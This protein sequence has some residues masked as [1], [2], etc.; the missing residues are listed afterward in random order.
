MK[1]KI[2]RL[3]KGI[4]EYEMPELIVSETELNIDVEEGIRKSGSIRIT[5]DAGKRMKGVLYV[6][7]KILM[8]GKTD[9]IGAECELEYEVDATSLQAGEEHVGTIDIISD[10]GECQIPFRIHVSEPVFRTSVGNIRDLFQFANLARIN[11][12]EALDLFVSEEFSKVV[13]QKEPKYRLAYEQLSA[14]VDKP[15]AME[16]FLVLVHKKKHC[17]FEVV[18]ETSEYDVND[19]NFMES[20]VIKKNQWGYINISLQTNAPYILLT[21]NEITMDDFINGQAEIGFVIEAEKLNRGTHYAEIV[22]SA[23]RKEVRLPVTIHKSRKEDDAGTYGKGLHRLEY[24]LTELYLQFRNN[25]VSS[26]NYLSESARLIESILMLLDKQEMGNTDPVV[27]N[28]IEEKKCLYEL[29]RA[30]LSIVDGKNRGMDDSYEMILSRK[31]YFERNNKLFYCAV[32]Y[33]E[34]MKSRDRR[35]VEESADIIR[36]YYEQ[37]KKDDIILWFLLYMDKRLENSKLLRYEMIKKHCG[38]GSVSRIL[39]FEAAM[40][41]NAEPM[42]VSEISSFECQIMQYLLK[43]KLAGKETALQFAYLSEKS[44]EKDGVQIRILK[45]LYEQ[46]KHRDILFALCKKMIRNNYCGKD[47]HPY[48]KQGIQE[49]LRLDRLNEYY[50]MTLDKTANQLIEQQALLYFSMTNFATEEDAAFVYSYVVRNKDIN[51]A[52]YRAYLKKMEQFAVNQMKAGVISGFHAVLYADVLRPSIIDREMAQQLPELIFTYQVECKDKKIQSVCVAHKE[53]KAVQIVPLEEKNGV[54]QALVKI[55][56]ENAE[57]F[58]I[59]KQ[60][61]FYLLNSEDKM[62]RLMHAENFLETCYEIGSDNRKLLLHMWEKNK[63]YNRHDDMMI[64]LQK[65][66]SQMEDLREEVQNNCVVALV[67]YYYEHYN[68]EFLESYLNAVNLKLLPTREREKMLEMMILRDMYD[69]VIE[70][71]ELFGCSTGM[72]AKRLSKLCVRG[73]YSSQEERDRSTL[74]TMGHYAFRYGRVEDRLLQY[75]VDRYNGTTGDMCELWKAAKEREL[76]TTSLE[77]RLLA[78][79]L[80]AES[81]VEDSFMVFVSYCGSGLNRKLIRA[82]FS[83]CAYKY[84]VKDRITNTELFEMLKKESFLENNQICVLALLKYYAGKDMLVEAEKS[85]VN[86]HIQKFVQKKLIFGFYKEFEGKIALPAYMLD[87]YFVEYRTNPEHKLVIHYSCGLEDEELKTEEMVDAG[88][89]IFEKELILFYGESL[90]YF[91]TEESENGTEIVESRI[92]NHTETDVSFGTTK[93][94]KINEILVTKELQDEKTL[95][96]LLEQY[97]KEEYAI[98]RHFTPL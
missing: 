67:D 26:G 39:A 32:L 96:S 71:V 49:Q 42:A 29:Y 55:Y 16:E 62:F 48:Y 50:I 30:Y 53:E 83:Y 11:W 80:F 97:Y 7:G 87:K 94:G 68:V 10:C 18:N 37:D 20:L 8:L 98:K 78:Q 15:H 75:L 66:I 89:G 91:I 38:E 19:R 34:A 63:N 21:K 36:R 73:I 81:Y 60:G 9:F 92:I 41:W 61:R 70:S 59:D 90:Q 58:L 6:T 2:E 88:Y 44:A 56:T 85:F 47:D 93:Y 52:I 76:E 95:F 86:F 54:R 51:P 17:D 31:S 22:L 14:S 1:E 4:F 77:E 40:V 84:F 35:Q 13:L 33:L 3:S 46:F 64:E 12:K 25:S 74:L 72:Q 57:I 45:Q 23:G 5:N 79:M 69:K 65:Q 27:K 43:Y 24:R 28:G 82:Y